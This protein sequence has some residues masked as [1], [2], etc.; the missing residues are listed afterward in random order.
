MPIITDTT[1]SEK[2][3]LLKPFSENIFY[4][5]L[6]K[7]DGYDNFT[8]NL[9]L[10]KAELFPLKSYVRA[11]EIKQALDELVAHGLISLYEADGKPFLH[12]HNNR[13]KLPMLYAKWP[14][15]PGQVLKKKEPKKKEDNNNNNNKDNNKDKEREKDSPPGLKNLKSLLYDIA[16]RNFKKYFPKEEKQIESLLRNSAAEEI[17]PLKEKQLQRKYVYD[18]IM[19]ELDKFCNYHLAEIEKW[20]TLQANSKWF[21]WL[22]RKLEYEK[23]KT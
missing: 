16:V 15:A 18:P 17:T 8:A 5:L 3:N 6:M 23:T 4:R 12:L 19:I 9:K 13:Q 2:V 7:V 21:I 1:K 11:I 14:L 10:L 20:N 22:D